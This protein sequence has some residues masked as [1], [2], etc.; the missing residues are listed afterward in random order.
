MGSIFKIMII[1]CVLLNLAPQLK[2]NKIAGIPIL[3]TQVTVEITNELSRKKVLGLHCKDKGNDLGFVALNAGQTYRF[4]F[5]PNYFFTVTL[6]F[7]HFQWGAGEDH[8]F[9]IYIQGRDQYCSHNRCSW[10]IVENGPCKIRHKSRECFHWNSTNVA[11]PSA[12]N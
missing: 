11:S 1:L 9:D 4:R 8:H 5:Y 10:A 2:G 6:Y 12:I 7:C 3:P